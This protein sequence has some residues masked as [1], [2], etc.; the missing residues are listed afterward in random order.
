MLEFKVDLPQSENLLLSL[1]GLV[2]C[3]LDDVGLR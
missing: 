3:K 1:L 2:I